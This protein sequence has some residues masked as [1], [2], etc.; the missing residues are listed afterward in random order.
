MLRVGLANCLLQARKFLLHRLNLIFQRRYRTHGCLLSRLWC[1]SHSVPPE[2]RLSDRLKVAGVPSE[3]FSRRPRA[4]R[5][6]AKAATCVAR[7]CGRDC[8]SSCQEL[9]RAL[10][11]ASEREKGPVAARTWKA[12]PR[13]YEHSGKLNRIAG[14]RPCF[15]SCAEHGS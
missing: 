13:T 11:S 7:L 4:P 10:A 15:Q 8:S 14:K 9:P 1:G 12:V 2:L 3:F 5:R 6:D